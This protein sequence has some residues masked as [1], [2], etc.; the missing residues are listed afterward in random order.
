M[1]RGTL[2][3]PS[4]VFARAIEVRPATKPLMHVEPCPSEVGLLESAGA[5]PC[6]EKYRCILVEDHRGPHRT[7]ELR[8]PGHAP[9]EGR[10]TRLEWT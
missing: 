8:T 9:A 3:G 1:S 7:G 5:F 2:E 6:L 10:P 4:A